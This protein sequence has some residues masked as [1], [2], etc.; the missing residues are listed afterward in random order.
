MRGLENKESNW[1]L[2]GQEEY[3]QGIDKISIEKI[4]SK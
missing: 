1:R 2:Q 3:L 4:V